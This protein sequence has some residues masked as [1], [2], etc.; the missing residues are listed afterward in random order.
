MFH[1]EGIPDTYSEIQ[2]CHRVTE[3][4]YRGS[5]PCC[6]V[7]LMSR[8]WLDYATIFIS[9]GVIKEDTKIAFD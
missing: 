8:S 2:R 5:G 7:F 4:I 3:T 9:L 6:P 1:S